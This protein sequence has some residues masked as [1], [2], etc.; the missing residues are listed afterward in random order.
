MAPDPEGGKKIEETEVARKK[1]GIILNV[2]HINKLNLRSRYKKREN[3]DCQGDCKIVSKQ[4]C[5]EK[6]PCLIY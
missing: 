6:V 5:K 1:T 4:R 3:Q 2:P